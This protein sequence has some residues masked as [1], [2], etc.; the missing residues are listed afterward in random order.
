MPDLVALRNSLGALALVLAVL[1]IVAGCSRADAELGVSDETECV[2]RFAVPSGDE[3]GARWAAG[4][5]RELFDP[6]TDAER[7]RQ[8]ICALP[9]VAQAGSGTGTQQALESCNA[10]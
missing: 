3:S 1:I 5:C 8:V 7:R 9:K 4:A 10:A 2:E 6:D